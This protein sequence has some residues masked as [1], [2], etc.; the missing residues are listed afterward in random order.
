M[1][2]VSPLQCK[3]MFTSVFFNIIIIIIL[4]HSTPSPVLTRPAPDERHLFS[5][6]RTATSQ[7]SLLSSALFSALDC[8]E[9]RPPKMKTSWVHFHFQLPNG[10]DDT[11]QEILLLSSRMT[12]IDIRRVSHRGGGGSPLRGEVLFLRL[13]SRVIAAFYI[14]NKYLWGLHTPCRCVIRSVLRAAYVRPNGCVL[15]KSHELYYSSAWG[16]TLFLS[17]LSTPP[18]FCSPPCVLIVSA[19]S[20]V[21]RQVRCKCGW[22]DLHL[23][24][25]NMDA[26]E[27]I[28]Y[29]TNAVLL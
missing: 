4:I 27:E 14:M 6:P 20:G 2:N 9:E 29:Y 11:L 15:K 25:K 19:N 1:I 17:H 18:P 7:G 5:A 16:E 28:V 10:G 26:K 21:F 24:K 8:S 13:A 12:R 3:E 23:Q 22:C